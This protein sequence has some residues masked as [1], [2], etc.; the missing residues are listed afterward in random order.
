LK[1]ILYIAYTYPPQN[2]ISSIR[3]S[4]QTK[5]LEKF[6]YNVYVISKTNNIQVD[7]SLIEIKKDRVFYLKN[8]NQKLSKNKYVIFYKLKSFNNK[9]SNKLVNLLEVVNF[10]FL[11]LES[12]NWDKKA[13]KLCTEIIVKNNIELIYS[14]SAPLESLILA[15]NLSI[16]YNIPWISEFRDLFYHNHNIKVPI[17]FKSLIKKKEH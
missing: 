16:K 10:F 1:K 6:G 3:A 8:K 7:S 15:K 17:I 13:F 2:Q 11:R 5:Y 12:K 14:S 4:K 9:L